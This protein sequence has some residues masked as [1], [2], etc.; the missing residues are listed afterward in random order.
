MADGEALMA[1]N[2]HRGRKWFGGMALV[3]LLTGTAVA[4]TERSPLLAWFYVRGL[5]RANDVTRDRWVERAAGL[6]EA[7]VPDLL[8][9]FSNSDHSACANIRVALARL[10]SERDDGDA[11]RVKLVIRLTRGWD[12]FSPE[13]R[14]CAIEMMGEWFRGSQVATP[15]LVFGGGQAVSCGYVRREDRGAA[16][17]P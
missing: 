11:L 6:G 5:V 4:W 3:L 2:L 12:G 8:Q 13:G 1:G 14:A 10:S 16:S 7:V 15:E 17:R 9:G